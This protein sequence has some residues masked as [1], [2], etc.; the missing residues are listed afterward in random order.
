MPNCPFMIGSAPLSPW[1]T[2]GLAAGSL[3]GYLL[4][5]AMNPARRF[6]AESYSFMR[7]CTRVWL[8][9]GLSGLAFNAIYLAVEIITAGGL[10][11]TESGRWGPLLAPPVRRLLLPA[12]ESGVVSMGK[13]ITGVLAPLVASSLAALLF[14]TNWGDIHRRYLA[15]LKARM[16]GWAWVVEGITVGSS[17][18]CLW[19]CVLAALGKIVPLHSGLIA[20]HSISPGPSIWVSL[21]AL[22]F[23]VLTVVAVQVFII[24]AAISY[25]ESP[26]R[27]R[28]SGFLE[29]PVPE[30]L[31]ELTSLT[32]ALVI[33]ATAVR[34]SAEWLPAEAEGLRRLLNLIFNAAAVFFATVPARMILREVPFWRAMSQ[35]AGFLRSREGRVFWIFAIAAIHFFCYGLT[36]SGIQAATGATSAW[37]LTWGIFAPVLEACLLVWVLCA[38]CLLI[39]EEEARTVPALRERRTPPG[40]RAPRRARNRPSLPSS[41]GTRRRS[42]RRTSGG[43]GSKRS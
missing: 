41:P 35:N 30:R 12:F 33:V 38:W 3:A 42:R 23:A 6:F 16:G 39:W 15:A 8:W 34:V 18:F 10:T 31:A 13:T 1:V 27:L 40:K 11:E 9:V 32:T 29:L 19:Q 36:D 7:R 4:V 17:I 20:C 24:L 14:L 5:I 37:G 43:S 26:G 28:G 25:R 21:F 22:P 2:W